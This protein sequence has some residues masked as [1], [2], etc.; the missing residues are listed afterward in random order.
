MENKSCTFLGIKVA[1]RIQQYIIQ[2]STIQSYQ[3]IVQENE[4]IYRNVGLCRL[5]KFEHQLSQQ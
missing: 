2:I 1:V 3:S 5:C 4:A